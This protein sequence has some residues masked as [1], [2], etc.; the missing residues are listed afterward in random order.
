MKKT[1]GDVFVR[2]LVIGLIALILLI[3][4]VKTYTTNSDFATLT[5]AATIFIVNL[6]IVAGYTL[7]VIN[8]P[9]MLKEEDAPDLAYYLGF[10][11][12]VASLAVSF[13]SD[14]GLASDAAAKSNLVKG[15][16][17]QFGA[18]LLATLIGLISKIAITSKQSLIAS[19]PTQLYQE[20]R[21][22]IRSFESELTNLTTNLDNSIKSACLSMQT[23]AESAASS[24]EKL[25]EKLKASSEA[26]SESL[27]IEKISN[28][29][30]EFSS[31][32]LKLKDPAQQLRTEFVQLTGGSNNVFKGFSGLDASVSELTKK[33]GEE[34]R[35]SSMLVDTNSRLTEVGKVN[36]NLLEAQQ[37]TLVEVNKQL[38]RLRNGTGKAA[39]NY[40]LVA[41]AT[42]EILNSSGV[43][44]S[45]L[46]AISHLI[47]I[48]SKSIGDLVSIANSFEASISTSS[49]SLDVLGQK[50]TAVT[51]DLS[52]TALVLSDANTKIFEMPGSIE[53]TITSLNVLSDSLS[54]TTHSAQPF[55]QSLENMSIPLNST[56][57]STKSLQ[58]A[59]VKLNQDVELLSS[60][61]AQAATKTQI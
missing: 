14:V 15:S 27:T 29:I 61:L 45:D 5:L 38:T 28:P 59:I 49:G 1:A 22:E 32:L 6:M 8:N 47:Q 53:K 44:Q 36:I 13:I 30:A 35:I 34:V 20:F 56:T 58:L 25:S 9:E 7:A 41:D 3:V 40:Q 46:K 10:S 26:I 11:L 2:F 16:L 60:I 37:E 4:G 43:L 39:E 18:G 42:G 17:A 23:S 55:A 21:T 33:I 24:M 52:K 50:A 57:D 54:D 48:V 31:E 12:T 51:S 19:N